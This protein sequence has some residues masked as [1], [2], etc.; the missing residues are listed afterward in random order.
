MMSLCCVYFRINV[1]AVLLRFTKVCGHITPIETPSFK[2]VSFLSFF[3]FLQ[4]VIFVSALL[5]LDWYIF[6]YICTVHTLILVPRCD[7]VAAGGGGIYTNI[8]AGAF[9][10]KHACMLSV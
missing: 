5:P 6:K 3:V 9:I 7:W 1:F 10:L 4:G 8:F 2:L